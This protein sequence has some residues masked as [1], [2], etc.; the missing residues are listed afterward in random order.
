MGSV[1]DDENGK[2]LASCATRDGVNVQYQI[3][4]GTPT[5]KCAALITGHHRSLCTYLE[6]ANLFTK[7][8]L[9]QPANFS[10]IEKAQF[11]YV[12]VSLDNLDCNLTRL[13]D[14]V[15]FV[16]YFILGILSYC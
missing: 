2:T 9:M 6:A 14:L 7:E 8:H 5:G 1:G 12:T 3:Q 16:C 15:T 11:Y 10:Y 13:A 4:K